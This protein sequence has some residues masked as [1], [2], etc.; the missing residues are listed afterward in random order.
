MAQFFQL[1]YKISM[2]GYGKEFSDS[3]HE[4]KDIYQWMLD[5]GE[6][7]YSEMIGQFLELVKQFR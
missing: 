4:I 6:L 3:L 7:H 2:I 1:S 5:R